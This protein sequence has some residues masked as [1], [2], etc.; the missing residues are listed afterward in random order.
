MKI[1]LETLNK[2]T[3]QLTVEIKKDTILNEN[4]K[5]IKNLSKS[6]QLNGFRKGKIPEKVITEKFGEDINQ[7]TINKIIN[8]CLKE[9]IV[10]ENIN[11]IDQPSIKLQQPNE[12]DTYIYILEFEIYPEIKLNLENIQVKKYTS[13]ISITD[14]ENE[15]REY[16]KVYGNWTEID[17][18]SIDNDIVVIDTIGKK[19]NIIMEKYTQNNLEI[20]LNEKNDTFH[21]IKEKLLNKKTNQTITLFLNENNEL[22]EHDNN[23]EIK[24]LIKKIK[25]NLLKEP[26][27]NL[28]EKLGV[29]NGD[30]TKIN[31]HIKKKLEIISSSMENKI[32]RNNILKELV[33]KH[34]FEIPTVLIEKE[35][36]INTQ[37]DIEKIKENI[38]IKLL[39]NKIKTEFNIN[40]PNEKIEEQFKLLNINNI[41]NNNYKNI[42]IKSIENNVYTEEIIENI[43]HKITIQPELI[44]FENLV[45]LGNLK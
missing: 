16:T 39:L 36:K 27:K 15:I 22:K 23:I 37:Q 3:K 11:I 2:L 33:N 38:K 34:T 32:L 31:D 18:E 26:D 5:K 24:I 14:I 21:N 41:K 20:E 30:I 42:L 29:I 7:E 28:A 45:K 17:E 35:K 10:K 43:K 1:K 13:V 8:N 40:V 4:K 9:T 6:I 12:E 44:P 25:R 19:N